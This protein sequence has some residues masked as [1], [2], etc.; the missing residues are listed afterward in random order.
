MENSETNGRWVREVLLLK[1]KQGKERREI[2]AALFENGINKGN[3]RDFCGGERNEGENG[4]DGWITL[5]KN[6]V[7]EWGNAKISGH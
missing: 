3:A 1:R 2:A 7:R 4:L 5:Q 6:W